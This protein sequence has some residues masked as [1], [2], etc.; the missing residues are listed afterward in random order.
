MPTSSDRNEPRAQVRIISGSGRYADPW[1]DFARTSQRIAEVITGLGHEVKIDDR[2]EDALTDLAGVDLV[3]VNIGN[4]ERHGGETA[5]VAAAMGGLREH[6]AAGGG[7]LSVH[8]SATSFP[9]TPAWEEIVGGRWIGGR[10]MHPRIGET[11]ITINTDCHPITAGLADLTVWDERYSY[12]RISPEV[13]PLAEH[14]HDG[15]R[16]V[17]AWAR[18]DPRGRVVFDGLGHGVRSYDSD[19]RV[20]LLRREVQWLLGPRR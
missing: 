19:S 4:P 13:V 6:L 16:H 20:D 2:V 3:V 18:D 5:Q 14:S 11:T 17:M 9:A 15:L 1:H 8:S 10:S 7:L 12:L